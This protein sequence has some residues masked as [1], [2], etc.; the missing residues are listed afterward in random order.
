[1][2]LD[3]SLTA[4]ML[5]ARARIRQDD[6]D[7]GIAILLGAAARAAGAHFAVRSELALCTAFAYWMKREIEVAESFLTQVDP[8]SDLIHARALELQAWCHSARRDYRR[9]AQSFRA[10]LLRLD[11]CQVG[12]RALAATAIST[13]AIFAAELFDR[14][15][16]RFVEARAR[17]VDWSA[18]LTGHQ[19]VML[20][21]QALFCEFAGDTL[22]AYQ[23]AA[24]ARE[25]A[26]T[27]P[28]EV[29]AWGLS[30]ALARNAGEAYSAIVFAKRALALVETLDARELRGEESFSL[31][32]VAESCAHFDPDRAAELFA[33]Y[34]GLAPVDADPRSC[35]DP[36]LSADETFIA[37]VIAQARGEDDRAQ[38]CYRKAYDAF[39]SI[40]YVRRAATAGHALL[41][42]TAAA[43]VRS[44]LMTQLASTSNY[45]TASLK[46]GRDVAQAGRD[47][48]ASHEDRPISA[49]GSGGNGARL[50]L[51]LA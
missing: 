42:L 38:T 31:L 37:G 9:S 24:Q 5:V 32:S 7:A 13:L 45:I 21:H 20:A 25:A 43:D 2:T 51:W 40:G 29:S 1:V 46:A 12:D 48:A 50:K 26:P 16:A 17:S 4:E 11:D 30:S 19:Y 39:K 44:Y 15:L 33:R 10:T 35:V 34:W 41:K 36:R 8:R 49:S 22:A 3:A 18:G 27:V 23:F 47:V 28:F 6:A 14:D